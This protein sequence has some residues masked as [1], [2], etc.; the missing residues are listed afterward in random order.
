L[1]GK[2]SGKCGLWTFAN[3]RGPPLDTVFYTHSVVN[4][5]GSVASGIMYSRDTLRDLARRPLRHEKEGRLE[6]LRRR[7]EEHHAT[8]LTKHDWLIEP[9]PELHPTYGEV[10]K[11]YGVKDMELGDPTALIIIDE[12][13]RLRM[14]SLEQVRA[15]FDAIRGGGIRSSIP[16]SDSYTSFGAWDRRRFAKEAARESLVIGKA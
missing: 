2:Q 1:L 5:P 6:S 7:D 8:L 10:A 9:F 16:E 12:A 15:I 13:D 11:E 4:A 3:L 14:A